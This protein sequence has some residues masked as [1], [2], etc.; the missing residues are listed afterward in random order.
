M[1]GNRLIHLPAGTMGQQSQLARG[2]V[3]LANAV[4][5][6]LKQGRRETVAADFRHW[7]CRRKNHA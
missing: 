3:A 2:N 6:M 1:P 7:A 5:Q 4:E